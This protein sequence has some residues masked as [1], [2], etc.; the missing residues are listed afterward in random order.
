MAKPLQVR[1]DAQIPW[2]AYL[3]TDGQWVA[4]CDPLGLT[5]L[6]ANWDALERTVGEIQ[7]DLFLGLLRDGELDRFLKNHGW[8]S[9][10]PIPKRLSK[11]RRVSMDVPR[12]IVA[13]SAHAA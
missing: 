13:I 6:G 8:K 1:I 7:N 4:E 11:S 2:R 3:A 9:N 5:A 12:K 10:A